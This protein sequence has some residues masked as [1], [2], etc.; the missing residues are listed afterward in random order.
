M[1]RAPAAALGADHFPAGLLLCSELSCAA[2]FCFVLSCP[3]LFCSVCPVL[4]WS[5]LSC[6]VLLLSGNWIRHR[7]LGA[8]GACTQTLGA[9]GAFEGWAPGRVTNLS[10]KEE[11][12]PSC[13]A[14]GLVRNRQTA[15]QTS[16]ATFLGPPQNLEFPGSRST[17]KRSVWDLFW[18]P[19]KLQK[20]ITF[21]SFLITF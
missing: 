13:R 16:T 7:A 9:A 18:Y 6:A 21:R 11:P 10:I 14:L 4:L 19:K 5:P 3:V 12:V 1:L 2:L 8:H 15:P 20:V 17:P